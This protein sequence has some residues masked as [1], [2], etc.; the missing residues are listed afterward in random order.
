MKAGPPGQR[1]MAGLMLHQLVRWLRHQPVDPDL[2]LNLL[3]SEL[4]VG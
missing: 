2:T 4:V 1:S 3:A